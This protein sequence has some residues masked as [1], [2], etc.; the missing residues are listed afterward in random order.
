VRCRA[1]LAGSAAVAAVAL[2]GCGPNT[3]PVAE[4][5]GPGSIPSSFPQSQSPDPTGSASQI[6]QPLDTAKLEANVCAGLTDGQLIVYMGGIRKKDVQ[7]GTNGPVCVTFPAD[8]HQ[9]DVSISVQNIPA[10]TEDALYDSLQMFP[11]RQKVDPILGYPAVDSAPGS[12]ASTSGQCETTVAVNDSHTVMVQF[13]AIMAQSNQYYSK[14][15]TA[16]E[17]LAKELV[18]NLK[19]GGA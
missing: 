10:P 19:T 6:S 3:G 15:C 2:A 13:S 7:T 5:T 8:A 14:A 1:V 18:Q 16:S 11:W 17:A 9:P 12:N 4:P